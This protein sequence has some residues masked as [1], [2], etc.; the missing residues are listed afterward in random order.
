M[1]KISEF[2]QVGDKSDLSPEKLLVI[3]ETMYRDLAIAINRKPDVYERDVDGQ[4][5]D[6]FLSNGDIN[7]NHLT[8]KVEM[9][10]NHP[11]QTTVTWTQLS[12]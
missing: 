4:S 2:F 11:T 10:T 8:D 3:I 9:I 7:I 12:P 1:A 6:Y 5:S